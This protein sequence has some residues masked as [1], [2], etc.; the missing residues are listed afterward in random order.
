MKRRSVRILTG[1]IAMA[2]VYT[3]FAL[4]PIG[5]AEP[6]AVLT[7]G[8][9]LALAMAIAVVASLVNWSRRLHFEVWF[10]L[11]YLNLAAVAVEGR[12]FAPAVARPAQLPANLA[13][14][15]VASLGVAGVAAAWFGRRQAGWRT[16]PVWP[17]TGWVWRLVVAAGVYF[18]LYL[19]IGGI[20]FTL[21]TKPY[22]E[23]HAGGVS[24]PPAE[25]IFVYEPVRGL[26][27][28]LSVLL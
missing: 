26:M 7:L 23:T 15:A 5:G 11:L 25:V 8:C 12:L 19:V 4:I 6:D 1:A 28:A 3:A 17:V 22:Y 24:M 16:T 9:A 10:L 20:N 14:L 21:V 13:Q 27:I 18:V 2:A